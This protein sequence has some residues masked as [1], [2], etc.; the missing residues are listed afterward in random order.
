MIDLVAFVLGKF[1]KQGFAQAISLGSST[2]VMQVAKNGFT[3]LPVR[4]IQVGRKVATDDFIGL[5][6]TPETET[7]MFQIEIGI[8]FTDPFGFTKVVS[9]QIGRKM[10]ASFGFI[11]EPVVGPEDVRQEV[12][13]ERVVRS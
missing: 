9:G 4:R 11:K 1:V 7:P 5:K 12:A 3:P 2:R 8:D 13:R 10:R 6:R